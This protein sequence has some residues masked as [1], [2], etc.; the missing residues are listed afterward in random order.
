MPISGRSRSA[1]PG[2]PQRRSSQSRLWLALG[3]ALALAALW[4]AGL[5]VFNTAEN[6]GPFR[7]ATPLPGI[8]AT[9]TA[10]RRL[11]TLSPE[12]ALPYEELRALVQACDE[13]HPN[14][15]RALLQHLDWL[16]HPNTAPVELIALYG[17]QWRAKIAFGAA[18]L[19]AVDWNTTGRKSDS[20]LVPIGARLNVL[21]AEM[22]GKPIAEFQQ[23]TNNR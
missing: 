16:T 20:C 11:P 9:V 2:R 17:E 13:L 19:T 1:K 10:V 23:A 21:L 22:G 5:Y 6:R 18:Y 4:G 12:E 8:A 15:Q 7:W 14:R 3:V